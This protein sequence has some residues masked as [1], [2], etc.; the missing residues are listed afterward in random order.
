MST[1]GRPETL[2]DAVPIG[3]PIENTTAYVL[4]RHGSVMPLGVPGELCLGG[5][6]VAAGYWKR[7]ELTQERFVSDPFGAGR[8][9]RTGDIVRFREDGEILFLGRRDRQVKVSGYR[10]E[11]GEVEAAI[12]SHPAVRTA[13]VV[14]GGDGLKHLEAF[15][16]VPGDGA[17][18]P[19]ALRAYLTERLPRYMVPTLLEPVDELP[20][21][22]NGK[23]DVDRL[24]RRPSR[25]RG[26]QDGYIAPRTATEEKL[27]AMWSQ[28]LDLERVGVRDNFFALGGH[29]LVATRLLSRV[30][31]TFD[32]EV[33]MRSF[34]DAPTVE[35]M[36]R[37]LG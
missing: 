17:L 36:A 35:D 5:E 1:I 37:L 10:V 32:A 9:Y 2:G 12:C 11:P 23:L 19:D 18:A 7:P 21:T 33:T 24:S 25:Q 27:V 34:F 31:A 4:D 20:L 22:P 13:A 14:T 16:E 29:S 15:Y 28:L 30:R 8:L 26:T 3:R 6:G